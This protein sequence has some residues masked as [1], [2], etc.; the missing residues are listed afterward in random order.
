MSNLNESNMAEKAKKMLS[1][2]SNIGTLLG[3]FANA[4]IIIVLSYTLVFLI[5]AAGQLTG[6]GVVNPADML[7]AIDPNAFFGG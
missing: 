6:T 7:E 4:G 5:N 2:F 1:P 3:M